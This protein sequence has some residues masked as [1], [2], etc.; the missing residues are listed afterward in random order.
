MTLFIGA[1]IQFGNRF[2][3]H[4]RLAKQNLEKL[5]KLCGKFNI[6]W[7]KACDLGKIYVC[8]TK[9]SDL[10]PKYLCINDKK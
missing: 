1:Y 2:D 7:H 5:P 6:Y 3:L 4:P 9:P 8:K 10:Q